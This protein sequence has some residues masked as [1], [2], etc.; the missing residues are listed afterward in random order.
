[1]ENIFKVAEVVDIG[2]E[3]EKARR[4]FYSAVADHFDNEDMKSLFR[5]LSDWEESH[6]KKFANIRDDLKETKPVESYPGELDEY[7]KSLVSDKLYKQVS[8]D[9]FSGNVKTPL[10]AIDY[11]IE[12]EKDAILLFAELA[13]FVKTSKKDVLLQLIEEERQHIMYLNKL[14]KKFE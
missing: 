5:R 7:M 2:I 9:S 14:R 13:R 1:M 8:P 11:G 4:D 10:Q 3:K 12:F 6:V